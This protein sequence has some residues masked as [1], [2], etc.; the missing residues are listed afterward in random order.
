MELVPKPVR[1]SRVLKALQLF[2]SFTSLSPELGCLRICIRSQEN[3]ERNKHK[4]LS[5]LWDSG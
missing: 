5:E 1:D 3:K 4:P 2:F